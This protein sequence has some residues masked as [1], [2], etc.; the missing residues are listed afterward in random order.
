[1]KKE[2]KLKG[3]LNRQERLDLIMLNC[4]ATYA[5]KKVLNVWD[6]TAS[7]SMLEKKYIKMGISFIEKAVVMVVKRL[8]QTFADQLIRDAST[9]D[10]IVATRRQ[11]AEQRALM[12][13][14]NENVACSYDTLISL[15][16]IA[17]EQCSH[18]TKLDHTQCKL[19][20]ICM[21]LNLPAFD[22][23]ATGCQYQITTKIEEAC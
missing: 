13:R 16:E 17:V 3:Y 11:V 20:T 4:M 5:R 21:E 1:M 6:K 22:E 2:K 10:I 7:F 23:Y 19:R 12:Q 15:A 9:A 8:D 18:C 14:A